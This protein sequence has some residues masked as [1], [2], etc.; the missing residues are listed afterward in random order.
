[1][2]GTGS[3]TATAAL[4]LADGT[5]FR[6]RGLGARGEAGECL[7]F[8]VKGRASV[9]DADGRRLFEY[10][11]GDVIERRAGLG[12][13]DASLSTVAQAP[14]R[15]M[16]LASVGRL[17]LESDGSGLGVRLCAYLLGHHIEPLIA[18]EA[19]RE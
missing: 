19:A 14:C 18:S 5:V 3:P 1:M 15:T 9:H 10:G 17:R 7:H 6:G 16:M 11:P 4:A 2:S 8:L 13:P 12:A